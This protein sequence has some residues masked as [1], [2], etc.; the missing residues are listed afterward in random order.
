[1]GRLKSK[2]NKPIHYPTK[3]DHPYIF[4]KLFAKNLF[5]DVEDHALI[6]SKLSKQGVQLTRTLIFKM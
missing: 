2:G 1:M 6:G 4:I 5:E 3:L